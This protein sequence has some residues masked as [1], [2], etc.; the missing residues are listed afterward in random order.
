MMVPMSELVSATTR[1]DVRGRR[2]G[3]A[4]RVTLRPYR[5][6]DDAGLA[7]VCLATA[8]D[9][10]DGAALYANPGLPGDVYVLPYVRF[11]PD[12]CLVVDDG[13][14]EGRVSG[15][16]LGTSDTAAFEHWAARA[17]WP[18]T[19]ARYP[20]DAQ[21][22]GSADARLA[23][24]AAAP[25]TSPRALTD[26]YP[27]H[28][29]VDLLPHVQGQ[30]LGRRLLQAFLSSA[31]AAGAS[32]VHLGVSTSNTRAI[33]FYGRLGFHLVERTDAALLL[34]RPLP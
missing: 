13:T 19:R 20:L 11:E 31:H 17:W 1:H 7:A 18:G 21:A 14:R 25:V 4:A 3:R 26:R 23:A 32:G 24:M 28:L 22:P 12:L 8:A 34:G 9:G 27:A 15:Y 16:V 29:H 10:G 33:G 6:S 2:A 30:G 5:R